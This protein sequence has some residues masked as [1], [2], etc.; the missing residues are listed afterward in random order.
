MPC[1]RGRGATTTLPPA[2]RDVVATTSA[3]LPLR[4]RFGRAPGCARPRR[5]HI[6]SVARRRAT[7][8]ATRVAGGASLRAGAGARGRSARLHEDGTL[9]RCTG[10]HS[11]RKDE[12]PTHTKQAWATRRRCAHH[13][14]GELGTR[15]APDAE[16][17]GPSGLR[18]GSFWMSPRGRPQLQK[19]Q[20][21]TH[22]TQT[23]F[24]K[25]RWRAHSGHHTDGGPPART[26]RTSWRREKARTK[27]MHRHFG[28]RRGGAVAPALIPKGVLTA[29]HRTAPKVNGG[30]PGET[31]A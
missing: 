25:R 28:R 20:G 19:F 31:S 10:L 22:S 18:Q 5:L 8:M 30:S 11:G 7:A 13:A 4:L 23:A 21:R 1:S 6:P 27:K 26:T 9:E 16:A 14:R 12:H 3:A 2:R 17:G 29:G 24:A 15:R